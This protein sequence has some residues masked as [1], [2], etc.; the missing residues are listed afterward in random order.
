[1]ARVL[2]TGASGFLGRFVP[3]LLAARGHEVHLAGRSFDGVEWPLP[4]PSDCRLHHA[5]LLSPDDIRDLIA[6]VRP[7][8]LLH[9]AW[10]AEPGKFWH[11]P[12]NL[13]WVAAS[14]HL[15]RAFAAAGGQRFVG[16]GSC[17]EYDW[18]FATLSA[19]KTPLNPSTPYG[20]A[21]ARLFQLLSAAAAQAGISFAWGRIF[22]PFGP[23]EHPNRLLPQV[24]RGLL[25]G[26]EVALSEGLQVR[27]F[28]YSEDAARIFADL[29]DSPV[30][31][32]VNVASGTG[33]SVRAFAELAADQI[34]HPELLHFGARPPGNDGTPYMVAERASADGWIDEASWV[35]VTAGISRAIEWWRPISNRSPRPHPR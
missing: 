25:C 12:L 7:T 24:I 22:F 29:V 18:S 30:E 9:L 34:G 13:D 4:L 2:V 15:F 8:H 10:Y 28:I 19:D 35:G 21:K 5:D 27:D 16:A 14:L 20:N 11:S 3:G 23:F 1:M 6:N 17:A 32:A 31:G 26:K 33:L